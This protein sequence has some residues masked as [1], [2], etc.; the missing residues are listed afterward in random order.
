MVTHCVYRHTE[1]TLGAGDWLRFGLR[2][3]AAP[4]GR[5]DGVDWVPTRNFTISGHACVPARRHHLWR[6]ESYLFCMGILFT[7]D[8]ASHLHGTFDCA[9][10]CRFNPVDCGNGAVRAV[11]SAV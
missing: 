4:S 5:V 6:D 7:R 3:Y 9:V 10:F 8:H 2:G 11:R 1:K